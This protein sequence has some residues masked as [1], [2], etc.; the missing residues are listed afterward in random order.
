EVHAEVDLVPVTQAAVRLDA[1]KRVERADAGVGILRR[2]RAARH[3]PRNADD[4]VADAYAPP[5]VLF[6]RARTFELEQHPEPAAVDL[7]AEL[8]PEP[9]A[10]RAREHRPD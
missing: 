7:G 1:R 9:L 8:A 2:H 3:R 6:V 4:C 5:R 10:R